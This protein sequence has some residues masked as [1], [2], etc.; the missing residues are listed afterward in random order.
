MAEAGYTDQGN[1]RWL[2][3]GELG[4]ATVPELL[5]RTARDLKGEGALEVDLAGVTR[6][7]SAGLALLVEWT[8]TSVQAG[9]EI[10]FTH[11]PAQLQS[12]AEVCGLEGILPLAG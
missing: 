4:Y 7:D 11:V 9:R 8:R 10:R 1:G 12:I 6:A 2:V 3:T 5:A